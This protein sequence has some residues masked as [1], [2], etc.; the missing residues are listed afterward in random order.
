MGFFRA[1]MGDFTNT[2]IN[3][4]KHTILVGSG[5]YVKAPYIIPPL[6]LVRSFP[7]I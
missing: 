3:V 2:V 6:Q 5:I 4:K 1:Q 7:A